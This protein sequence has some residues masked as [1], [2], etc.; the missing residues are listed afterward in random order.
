MRDDSPDGGPGGPAS[1]GRVLLATLVVG[2]AAGVVG[3]ALAWSLLEIQ[4]LAYG[5][6]ADSLLAEIEATSP[7]RRVLAPA[8]GGLLAGLGWWW[9][10]RRHTPVDVRSAMESPGRMGLLAPLADGFLQILV[11]GSGASIGREGAPRLAAGAIADTVAVRAGL[12]AGQARILIAGGAGAG[13]AAVYNVPLSGVAFACELMLAWRPLSALVTAVPMSLIATVVAWPVVTSQP[14]Y[15]FPAVAFD[16]GTLVWLVLAVPLSALVGRVFQRTVQ[17]AVRRRSL[18][19]W[20]LSL[21]VAAAGAVVGGLS[22]WLPMLPGNGKDLVQVAFD[23]GGT[24]S[25]FLV[26]LLLKPVVTALCLGSGAVGGLLT[27]ALATGAALGASAAL[28]AQSAG[29]PADVPVCALIGACGVLAV[30]QRAPVFAAVMTWELTRSPLWTFP[31]L[32]AI[33]L[34]SVA[35]SRGSGRQR[36]SE[37]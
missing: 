3:A 28:A 26:L 18:P 23:S 36:P 29:F 1:W 35:L 27:P 7:A 6:R 10:R 11:V 31:L 19:G 21:A 9:L 14:T 33:A 37:G 8:V 22:L 12:D 16:P 4:A 32:L 20:R 25:L 13:L 34:G 5:V 30:T 2:L 24:L 15:R 17:W